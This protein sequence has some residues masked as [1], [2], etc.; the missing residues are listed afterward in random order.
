M[1]HI[2]IFVGIVWVGLYVRGW[3]EEG[4]EHPERTFKW[5]ISN[6]GEHFGYPKKKE[7]MNRRDLLSNNLKPLHKDKII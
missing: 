3:I 1:E 7:S 5:A 6:A 4:R 2:D